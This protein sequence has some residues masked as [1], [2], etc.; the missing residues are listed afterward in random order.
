MSL[1]EGIISEYLS[2]NENTAYTLLINN[3]VV[4]EESGANQKLIK[5]VYKKEGFKHIPKVGYFTRQ[6]KEIVFLESEAER[7]AIDLRLKDCSFAGIDLTKYVLNPN[8]ITVRV[9]HDFRVLHLLTPA[10]TIA[11]KVALQVDKNNALYLNKVLMDLGTIARLDDSFTVY[12]LTAYENIVSYVLLKKLKKYSSAKFY[13][14]LDAYVPVNI[15]GDVDEFLFN[16]YMYLPKISEKF[17]RT[18]IFQLSNHTSIQF[19]SLTVGFLTPKEI[20]QGFSLDRFVAINLNFYLN[21][22]NGCFNSD[23]FNPDNKVYVYVGNAEEDGFEPVLSEQAYKD[24]LSWTASNYVKMSTL[25]RLC[26]AS[27]KALKVPKDQVSVF[28]D[29]VKRRALKYVS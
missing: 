5:V 24:N 29:I 17:T 4:L 27:W 10:Y 7:T 18:F 28:R 23:F 1:I 22:L 8:N 2:N 13:F 19:N 25:D 6:N 26:I 3:D 21:L 20:C 16:P 15:Y 11:K 12:A 9:N 14:L